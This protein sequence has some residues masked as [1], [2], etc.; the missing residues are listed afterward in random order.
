L[1]EDDV[2]GKVADG[3]EAEGRVE[4]GWGPGDGA[5]SDGFGD[6]VVGLLGIMEVL[7]EEP[8]PRAGG[9]GVGGGGG[10]AEQ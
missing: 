5:G 8:A 10:A 6:G 2:E 7:G 1:L 4:G 3:E 9:G